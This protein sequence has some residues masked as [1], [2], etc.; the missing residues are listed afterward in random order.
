MG[1]QVKQYNGIAKAVHWTSALVV[2]AMFA[3]GVWMVELT[4]YSQWYKVAPHWHKSVGLLLAGL[5]LF[6]LMWKVVTK[7]PG[8]EGKPY[9]VVVAKLVHVFMYLVMLTLFISGYL[10]STEDGRGIDVFTWFTI[11]GAGQLFEGQADLAGEIH[12]LAAWTLIIMAAVHALAAVKH[13]VIDK[14]DTLRKMTG[15]TK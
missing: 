15:V 2:V 1:Q 5:T 14:D 3:V 13:H 7:S 9:E 12:E 10:I 6:R 4:Y 11:P 8:L